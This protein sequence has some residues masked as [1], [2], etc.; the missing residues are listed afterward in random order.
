MPIRKTT[1]VSGLKY[2][3]TATRGTLIPP[4]A[5]AS[6]VCKSNRLINRLLCVERNPIAI[7]WQLAEAQYTEMEQL[8]KQLVAL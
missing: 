5:V 2:R 3:E 1:S 6:N 8:I 7:G 4:V